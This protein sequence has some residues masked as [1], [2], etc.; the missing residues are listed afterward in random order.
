[1]TMTMTMTMTMAMTMTMM[2]IDDDDDDDDD[3]DDDADDGNCARAAEN[4]LAAHNKRD[5]KNA[6][7]GHSTFGGLPAGLAGE[8]API[9]GSTFAHV[10]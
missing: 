5:L 9:P 10:G 6:T 8:G 4:T 2:M 7:I 1:M 3:H